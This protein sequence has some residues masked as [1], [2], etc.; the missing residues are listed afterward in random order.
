MT[1]HHQKL[2]FTAITTG[3]DTHLK[4]IPKNAPTIQHAAK[5]LTQQ[6]LTNNPHQQISWLLEELWDQ[7]HREQLA[8]NYLTQLTKETTMTNNN[9]PNLHHHFIFTAITTG[10]TDHL[11]TIPDD[12]PDL[13]HAAQTLTH[14]WQQTHTHKT[15]LRHMIDHLNTTEDYEDASHTYLDSLTT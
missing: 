5:Y 11:N 10:Q 13:K 12:H 14:E 9:P 1:T 6:L 4:T 3:D 2:I 15:Q 8:A 7:E